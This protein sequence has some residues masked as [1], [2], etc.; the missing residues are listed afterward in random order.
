MAVCDKYARLLY[1]ALSSV[2]NSNRDRIGDDDSNGGA[3]ANRISM[4][5]MVLNKHAK[6]YVSTGRRPNR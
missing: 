3:G 6:C 5:V 1:F 2:D 4:L